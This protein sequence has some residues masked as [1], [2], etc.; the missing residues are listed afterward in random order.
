MMDTLSLVLAGVCLPLLAG[1]SGAAPPGAPLALAD[2]VRLPDQA[3][4]RGKTVELTLPPL[5]A[6]AGMLVVLSFRAVTVSKGQGGCNWNATVRVNGGSL[7]RFTAT[8]AERLV[9]RSSTLDLVRERLAFPVLSGGKQMIMYAKDADQGD[10]STTDGLGATFHLDISDVARGVDGNTLFIRN[11]CP[12]DL[13]LGAGLGDL[14][15]T[16]IAVGW[17]DKARLPKV[18]S[19]VPA[20]GTV[21]GGV[22]R[23]GV[24]LAQSR[25]GGFVVRLA[26]G[27]ELLVETAVGMRPGAPSVLLADDAA[28]AA[29]GVTFVA[30]PDGQAGFRL[31]ATWPGLTLTRQVALAD[32]QVAWTETWAN[33][34]TANRGVPFRQR[35]FLRD[36]E[37]W[38]TVGGSIDNGGVAQSACNPTLFLA[39]PQDKGHG[40]GI[41][42]ES[43]WLRLLT[44]YRGVRGVG[45]IY[46]EWLALAPGATLA[47][48]YTIAPVAAGG[49]WS[50]INGVRRRWGV[51]GTTMERAMFWGYA[52]DVGIQDIAA[53]WRQALAHLGPISVVLGPWQRLQPDSRVVTQGRYPKLPPEAPRTPGACPDL[54]VAAFL[55]F[56]HREPYWEQLKKDMAVLRQAVPGIKLYQMTHPSMEVVYRPLQERWPIAADAIQTPEGK[57]FESP[58]YSRA[59][60]H[61]LV[62]RD[63]GVLYYVPRPGSA[64]L[65]SLLANINRG[66]DECGLDGIY[67][68]EFS[69][70]FSRD[71][72]SRYDYS[73]WDGYSAELDDAGAIVRLKADAAMVTEECQ[74][75]MTGEVLKRG[76]FFL[77]NGGSALRSITGLPIHRFC[78]GGN[79]PSTWAQ[80]HLA[81][82]PLVLGNMGDEESTEG[83]F[84]SVKA[85]LGQGC[86]YSPTAVN[87]L[88]K[89]A[90]N[91]VCKQ[92]PLTVH[93]LGPGWV[94]GKER[95]LTTVSRAFPGPA[96]GGKV[97]VYNYDRQGTRLG[98]VTEVAAKAGAPLALTVLEGG[99]TIAEW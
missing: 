74:A 22:G 44:G 19:L 64:Q 12:V 61:E 52:S 71:G 77:G 73:R 26:D 37:A 89:G 70:A 17:L 25:G 76:K 47:C 90:D 50:F 30:E 27:L 21:A 79:G 54:D 15:V 9:G 58:V 62:D 13:D 42:A 33:T 4:P 91:F 68:D 87:L 18:P 45:E 84:E 11:E 32:G 88:L 97:T 81:A 94:V 75:R 85:C 1:A 82:V 5:P 72:Y 29:P 43:D 10:L 56:A 65:A 3:V 31:K 66:M 46:T 14:A 95:V 38:S 39:A 93:E 7:G 96:Q 24:T 55:T 99:L 92:Y 86:V 8:G 20:R 48:Q 57:A 6:K 36:Q 98:P 59:W 34:G 78:E 2:A 67:C 28:P 41:V 69:W 83:V 80:G 63:W 49:Y 60:L 53:R 23:A 40:F 16:S 51:N 35:F